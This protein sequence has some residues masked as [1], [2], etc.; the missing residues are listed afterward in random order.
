MFMFYEIHTF[1]NSALYGWKSPLEYVLWAS[2]TAAAL[3]ATWP[4]RPVRTGRCTCS[5][6]SISLPP[7][8]LSGQSGRD[9]HT[10]EALKVNFPPVWLPHQIQTCHTRSADSECCQGPAESQQTS[11]LGAES[12]Q[13]V[14]HQ[15]AER[16]RQVL[17]ALLQLGC[18]EVN[19]LRLTCRQVKFDF[20]I[21]KSRLAGS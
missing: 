7:S 13:A 3:P 20:L 16:L 11:V 12:L 18:K 1:L 8:G 4:L 6:V 19:I 17:E 2:W 5:V 10:S 14:S 9:N 15:L 21:S